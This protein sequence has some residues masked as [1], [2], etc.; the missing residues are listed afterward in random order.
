[1]TGLTGSVYASVYGT[2]LT[3]TTQA[4]VPGR[5]GAIAAQHARGVE[6]AALPDDPSKIIPIQE[7]PGFGGQPLDIPGRPR[8]VHARGH[9]DGSAAILPEKPGDLVHRGRALHLER[10]H[11]TGPCRPD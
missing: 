1:M 5:I 11:R 10:L 3:A 7:V 2:R 6:P 8:V 4:R 9:T